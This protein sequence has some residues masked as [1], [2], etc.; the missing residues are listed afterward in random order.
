MNGYFRSSLLVPSVLFVL[1]SICSCASRRSWTQTESGAITGEEIVSHIQYLASDELGGRRAG[2]E[3]CEQ[4]AKYV[5]Q[6]FERYGLEAVGD[7][8]TYFQNFEFVFDVRLG[9][10]NRLSVTVEGS[11]VTYTI[12]DDFLPLAFSAG[13]SVEGQAV[14]AGYGI[15]A[16]ELNYDDYEGID[17]RGKIVLAL[18]YGPEGDDPKSEYDKYRPA[19]YKA[20]TAREKGAA[21]LLLVTGPESYEEDEIVPLK[22]DST[23]QNSGITVLSVRRE[24]AAGI[25]RAVGR[26]LRQV[27]R[28]ID[29]TKTPQSFPIPEVSLS[30]RADVIQ[31][32]RRTSNVVGFLEGS[33]PELKGELI[34]I[35]A[36]Y[37]HLGLGQYGSRAP[38]RMGEVHNGADDNASGV[39]ALLELAEGFAAHRAILRRSILFIGFGAEE[40]GVLGSTYYVNHPIFEL[41]R[42]VT[43]INIDMVGRLTDDNLIINGAGTA[44]GWDSLLTRLN[45]TPRF[46]LALKRSGYAPGDNTPFYA[47]GVPILFFFTGAHEDYHKPSD[48]TDRINVDGEE[49]IV[50]Y[51]YSIAAAIDTSTTRPQLAKVEGEREPSTSGRFRVYMGTV[52][53]FAAEVEGVKLAGVKEGGPAEKAGL[54]GGDIIIRLGSKEITN[55]YDYTYALGQHRPGDV[56][57]VTAV[58]DGRSLTFSVTLEKRK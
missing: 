23:V 5:A 25:L 4:A 6:E 40:I 19:R 39:A 3:G 27:Q 51:I 55:L 37:D 33:D 35:G 11:T 12:D 44:A 50:K 46:D 56:V 47:K 10:E 7:E 16:P 34:V 52:P 48:D 32:R 17:V 45:E 36:H 41:D 21:A 28:A 13:D 9:P 29:S 58:R 14:F 30:L 38:E 26:D 8:G 43:M 22:Y 20:M 42:T 49:R 1:L 31:E 54:R 15:S 57:E 18:R 2:T 24:I 53:D